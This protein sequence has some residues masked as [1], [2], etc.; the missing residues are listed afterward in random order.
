MPT[1]QKQKNLEQSGKEEKINGQKLTKE[2][3]NN[4]YRKRR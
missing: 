1:F 3:R 2:K 4:E